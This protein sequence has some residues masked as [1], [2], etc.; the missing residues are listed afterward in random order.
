[1]KSAI[2]GGLVGLLSLGLVAAVWGGEGLS[3]PPGA[4]TPPTGAAEPG[5]TTPKPDKAEKAAAAVKEQVAVAENWI[6]QYDEE[7]AKPE[8]KRD[9]KKLTTFKL[10]AAKAYM[11]A[12]M[13]AKQGAAALPKDE[14][15]AFLDQYEK[16]NREKA[17]SILLELADAARAKKDYRDAVTYYKDVLQ[18]DPGNTTA[19]AGLKA[20]LEEMKTGA[21]NTKDK[22]TGGGSRTGGKSYGRS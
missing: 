1:M 16:L 21:K 7:M 18:V 15:Q 10:N 8:K 14:K 2:V 6:K 11:A 9:A 13:Q 4:T 3:Q 17:I 20:T 5:T 22:N 19:E 12:A